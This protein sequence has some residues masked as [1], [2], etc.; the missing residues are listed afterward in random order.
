MPIT[1]KSA[2]P[3]R[4]PTCSGD[5]RA[6]APARPAATIR[7]SAA[8]RRGRDRR[9]GHGLAIAYYLASRH[10]IRNVAVFERSYIGAGGSGRNTTVL[11][12]NYKT[13]GDD[14]V[15]PGE[16]RPLSRAFGGTRPQPPVLPARAALVG[17]LGQSLR[18]QRERA[19]LNQAFGVDTVF[20]AP[21]DVKEA[22]PVVDLAGGG[23]PPDSRGCLP[24][25]RRDHP[26]QRRRLGVRGRRPAPRRAVH[27]GVEVTV[28]L[29]RTVVPRH[30]D[31]AGPR[32]RR[33]RRLRRRR[34]RQPRRRDGGP[35]AADRHPS[36]PGIRH[37]GIQAR[38][39]PNRCLAGPPG[40]RLAKRPR[41]ASCRRRDR[42]LPELLD[43]F[44]LHVP[45]RGLCPLHRSLSLHGEAPN[46]SSVDRRLR[47]DSGLLAAH[48]DDRGRGL[49]PQRGLGYLGLQGHADRRPLDGRA[50][51]DREGPALIAPFA[52]DRFRRDRAVSERAS[53]GT[54]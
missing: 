32:R 51:R 30:R 44:D 5:E 11:R 50:G 39:R 40:L 48:G 12:A 33:A 54:H 34:V 1:S 43:A 23:Q 25:S 35:P 28:T 6:P 10:G 22:C 47:H 37:G 36:A 9:R 26:P 3:Q 4:A 49:L 7:A 15:L 53:A 14:P 29:G 41:R 46:P 45:L 21:D 2:F 19:L 18:I 13:P 24:S 17:A 8:L 31:T 42:A 20:L 38:A 52:L 16:P 27:Q